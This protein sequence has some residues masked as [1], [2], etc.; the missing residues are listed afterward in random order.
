[1]LEPLAAFHEARELWAAAR[2]EQVELQALEGERLREIELL[3]LG[4]ADVERVAPLPGEDLDLQ[5]ELDRLGAADELRYASETARASIAGDGDRAAADEGGALT[6]LAFA[7]RALEGAADSD[8]ELRALAV[9]VHEIAVLTRE[10]SGD[11]AAYAAGVDDD[12]QRLSIA[13]ERRAELNRLCR[14][15]NTG[16]DGVLQ[17][18]DQAGRRLLALD[19]GGE[20]SSELDAIEQQAAGKMLELAARLSVA[21]AAAAA[22]LQRRVTSEL[23]ALSM[24]S[25]RLQVGL[26]SS[27][28]P[29]ESSGSTVSELAASLGVD[30]SDEVELLFSPGDG[31]AARPL[32]RSASG[33][34]LSRVVLALEVVLAAGLG[35]ASMIFDEVDAGIGGEAALEVG[36][37]LALLGHSRQV[38]CVTHLPQVAAFADRHL[39]VAKGGKRADLHSGV[40]VLDRPG[41]VRELSRML[42]G[43]SDSELARGH[44]AELL[45]AAAASTA[46]A[47]NEGTSEAMKTVAGGAEIRPRRRGAPRRS[48]LPTTRGSAPSRVAL[49]SARSSG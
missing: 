26:M 41:R 25:A 49:S 11:L 16:V 17:W 36:R 8:P 28:P 6:A 40:Q 12:P 2:R 3:R 45:E 24:T 10:L 13:Q 47:M 7:A 30:G 23:A 31:L 34:E 15:H 14:P 18:A 46:A 48:A 27:L 35:P 4:L 21:R 1:M 9:R 42:A 32:A 44:A 29:L 20:R 19:A 37:R 5:R 33:G 43:V 39:L 38:I 22:R